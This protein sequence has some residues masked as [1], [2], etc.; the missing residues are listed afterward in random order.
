MEKFR[1][2]VKKHLILC[3]ILSVLVYPLLIMWPIVYW[4]NI[5]KYKKALLGVFIAIL[6]F[7]C[8]I[9]FNFD[10]STPY[11]SSDK[12]CEYYTTMIVKNSKYI[13]ETNKD[14]GITHTDL[15]SYNL[16]ADSLKEEFKQLSDKDKVI[17][18]DNYLESD[19]EL[20]KYA[21]CANC[22]IG[23]LPLNV[24]PYEYTSW[25]VDCKNY[26]KEELKIR[27]I[28]YDNAE[29]NVFGCKRFRVWDTKYIIDGTVKYQNL[30][31]G[32]VVNSFRYVTDRYG[33][34]DS[35][36]FN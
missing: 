24:N 30:F 16:Y 26:I 25:I 3:I 12:K 7:I 11:I 4:D 10:T 34:M 23:N 13:S 19:N 15:K 28:D 36:I 1:N 27:N 31:G 35:C 29:I 5:K 18:F 14:K 22:N 8:Y 21:F 6:L 17:M 20:Q 2:F 32:T 9:C 33:N